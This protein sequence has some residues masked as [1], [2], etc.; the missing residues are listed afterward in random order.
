MNKRIEDLRKLVLD[1]GHKKF[2]GGAVVSLD[3]D[4][5]KPLSACGRAA[6]ALKKICGAETPVIL[7]EENIVFTRTLAK[8]P[9]GVFPAGTRWGYG[10]GNICADWEKSLTQGLLG[11]KKAALESMRKHRDDPAAADFLEAA[12]S[13]IDSVLNLAERYAEAAEKAG[14]P[15]IAGTLGNVPANRPRSYREALQSLKF[16]HSCLWL[17]SSHVGLG[18]FDQYMLPYYEADIENSVLTPAGAEELTADFFI[19]LNKDTDLYP[20]VQKGDNGQSMMLGGVTPDGK[21][22][23]NKLTWLV[24]KVSR[25]LG[26][27]DPKINLRVDSQTPDALLK[28]AATLTRRGLGFPQYA[29]DEV[30]I[31]ALIKHGYKPEDARNYTVAA[32][33]EFIIPGCGMDV[34]NIAAVSFPAAVDQAVRECLGKTDYETLESRVKDNIRSQV[35]HYIAVRGSYDDFPPNPF[36]SVLMTECLERGKD[37]CHGGAGYYNYGIHGSGSSNGADALAVVKKYIY[38]D[39]SVTAEEMLD[40]LA[41]NWDGHEALRRKILDSEM[42]TGNDNDFTDTLLK[43]LFDHFA[44]ACEEIK[45]NGRGGIVRPGTGSAMYYIWLTSQSRAGKQPEPIVAATADGRKEGDF[46]S[47]SL[48]PSPGAKVRGPLS[49]LKSF[50]HI[51]YSR[52][53]NGGPITMELSDTVFRNEESLEKVAM[54]VKIFVKTGCQQLQLNVLNPETLRDAQ[55][56]PEKHRNLI[57]RVWG[58]SGYFTELAPEY[59]KHIINRNAHSL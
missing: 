17:S 12:V 57:V 24:L 20:G 6:L 26:M 23:V 39:K 54:L 27:I 14:R 7:P 31:P 53:C 11:R 46:L 48:A 8:L 38:E 3:E 32:C 45:D 28:E 25:E 59:Q 9:E 42:K 29:N 15:D 51:D 47:S 55:K 56:H 52:V 2:R 19:S 33:W 41:A 30:V 18:R 58:W 43:K 36:Y 35:R 21:P 49:A 1:G 13:S 16:M 5:L 22:A 34:P 44:D 50:S 40:A 4:E 37:I 10:A